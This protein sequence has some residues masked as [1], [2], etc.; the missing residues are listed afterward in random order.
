MRCG[1]FFDMPRHWRMNCIYLCAAAFTALCGA[2][3]SS[4]TDLCA[5]ATRRRRTLAADSLYCGRLRNAVDCARN[6]STGRRKACKLDLDPAPSNRF[7]GFRRISSWPRLVDQ[8][9]ARRRVINAGSFTEADLLKQSELALKVCCPSPA[10]PEQRKRA[11]RRLPSTADHR[12]RQFRHQTI[13]PE[14]INQG[15]QP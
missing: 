10:C 11:A 14:S 6:A 7:S 2:A 8:S 3:A 15:A 1:T 4:C 5:W 13:R 12:P 9:D